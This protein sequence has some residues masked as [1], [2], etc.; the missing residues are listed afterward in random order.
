MTLDAMR[1][2]LLRSLVRREISD[3]LFAAGEVPSELGIY[4]SVLVDND[5]CPAIHRGQDE[6]TTSPAELLPLVAT[7]PR[8]EEQPALA[9]AVAPG[10]EPEPARPE[11]VTRV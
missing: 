9:D 5:L 10:A 7:G 6:P 4:L 2:G 11:A 3:I 1:A 8:G